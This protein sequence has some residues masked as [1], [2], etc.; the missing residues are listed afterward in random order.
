MNKWAEYT[1]HWD[2][3]PLDISPLFAEEVPAGKNG[4]MKC[5]DGKFAFENGKEAKFWGV[6]INS[7]AC[8]P[9]HE[10]ADKVARRLAKF[11]INLV[12]LHQFDADWATPNI[13]QYAKG[14]L[15]DT[16]RKLDPVS[17]DRLDYLIHAL[18]KEGIYIYM[19]LLVYRTFKEGDG[20][21]NVAG[22]TPNGAKPYSIFDKDLIALQ[23]E[24][25]E[26]LLTH[27]NPY[28]GLR[29]VDDP[30][31]AMVLITNENDMFNTPFPITAEPYRSR[32][33]ERYRQWAAVNEPG[34]QIP[35]DFAFD[36][37][38]DA[39]T[40]SILRFYHDVQKEYYSI[41][42]QYLRDL[43]V[44]VPISGNS[45]ARGLTLVSALRDMDFT[46]ANVYWDLWGNQ[47]SNLHL[48]SQRKEVFGMV[49][50]KVRMQGKPLFITEWDQV[51]PNEWRAESPLFIASM[52]CFQEWSGAS[53]HT[54]R[55]RSTPANCMGG[56]IL[57]GISYRQN[58]ETFMDPAKFGL[59]YAASIMFRRGDIAPAKETQVIELKKEDIYSPVHGMANHN[60]P[61]VEATANC[62]K[63]KVEIRLP[64]SE[65]PA[66][67]IRPDDLGPAG[68]DTDSV[69]SDTGELFRNWKDGFGWIDTPKTKSI[70]GKFKPGQTVKLKNAEITLNGGFTTLTLTSLS[71][72]DLE[73]A[74]LILVTAVGRADNT[75]AQYNKAHTERIS[76]GHGPVLFE[77][78]EATVKMNSNVKNMRLWSIDADGAYTGEVP[79]TMK[80]GVREFQIG[81]TY[82]SIYYLLSI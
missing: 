35:D 13:F 53:L 80:D 28:T 51:W 10:A 65:I 12:R 33:L 26:Q 20:L 4:F 1:F 27:V 2:D 61:N 48:A 41:M 76:L 15:C 44:K 71:G 63:H 18:K 29:L 32:L 62:E 30:A 19:D 7:A 72:E 5:E 68:D 69:T 60:L 24:Y 43:G 79:S 22:L 73:N 16:T 66:N 58:F 50:S 49:P 8:F 54:Y 59:F 25:A 75:D 47:G 46:C 14:T 3:A 52:G 17:L 55:Y 57:G 40:E 9:P 38:K 31:M 23:K 64:G 70:Y 67:A 78:T 36:F 56:T 45:W 21:E 11:G 77:V 39:P 37:R 82:P 42:D 34:L 6:L 74:R 81:E